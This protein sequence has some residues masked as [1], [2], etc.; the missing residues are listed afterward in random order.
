MSAPSSIFA[1]VLLLAL[2]PLVYQNLQGAELT[3]QT[4]D[5]WVLR[6]QAPESMRP[7]TRTLRRKLHRLPD[8]PK[9]G[10]QAPKK[11]N[12]GR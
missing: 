6:D 2:A 1:Y 10:P 8:G 12:P 5:R 7:I 4:Y 9:G 3:E 11:I